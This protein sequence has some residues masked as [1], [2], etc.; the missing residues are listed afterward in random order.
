MARKRAVESPRAQGLT[1][2]RSVIAAV[3][4]LLA[5]TGCG[6]FGDETLGELVAIDSLEGINHS[7]DAVELA[8]GEEPQDVLAGL[9]RSAITALPPLDA[10]VRR[11]AFV[12]TGCREDSAQLVLEDGVLDAQLLEDGSTEGQTDCDAPVY[13]LAVFDV[14]SADLPDEVE[15]P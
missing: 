10:D 15:L 1:A 2:R 7:N 9:G 14:S 12:E 6:I 5:A 11:F 8:P 13:F 4:A 3:T